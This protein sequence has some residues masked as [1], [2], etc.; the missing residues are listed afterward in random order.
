SNSA[1]LRILKC[2]TCWKLAKIFALAQPEQAEISMR[3][4]VISND[5]H[6][7]IILSWHDLDLNNANV[8]KFLL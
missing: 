1:L 2:A 8:R 6:E 4:V 3:P 7:Q 5:E